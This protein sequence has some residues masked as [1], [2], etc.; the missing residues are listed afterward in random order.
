[1]VAAALPIVVGVEAVVRAPRTTLAV[2]I[3]GVAVLA[4]GVGLP[5]I[6]VGDGVDQY[7]GKERAFARWVIEDDLAL[8]EWPFPIDPT[9]VA[10]RVTEMNQATVLQGLAEGGVRAERHGEFV[11]RGRP[12]RAFWGAHGEVCFHV[13]PGPNSSIPGARRQG[14]RTGRDVLLRVALRGVTRGTGRARG[15]RR[16]WWAGRCSGVAVRRGSIGPWG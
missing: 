14:W 2:L 15:T 16:Y 11:G 6:L 13:R 1:M 3:C 5:R 10:R 7:W 9:V 12:L 4:L 8:K